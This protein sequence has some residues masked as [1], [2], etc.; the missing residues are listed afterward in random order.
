MLK[1]LATVGTGAAAALSSAGP[2]QAAQ[3]KRLS[4]QD[5]RT[6]APIVYDDYAA[7][8]SWP[9]VISPRKPYGKLWRAW[10]IKVASTAR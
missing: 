1:Q 7:A 5:A 4:A 10:P 3:P 6:V 2:A 8:H 9:L